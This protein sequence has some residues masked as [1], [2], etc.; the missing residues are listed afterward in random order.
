[1]RKKEILMSLLL[2]L[3]IAGFLSLLASSA[4]DGLERIAEDKG[5]LA[6]TKVVLRA[7]LPDYL[8]PGINNGKAASIFSGVTGT[9]LMFGLGCSAAWL[10]RR[11]K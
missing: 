2:I 10:L 1:M 6:R 5:F 7:P 9:L 4:P 3:V 11:K 8:W